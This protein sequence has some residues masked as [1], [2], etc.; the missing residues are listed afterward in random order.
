MTEPAELQ[1]DQG[2]G[3]DLL[4][5]LSE[6]QHH[7]RSQR[8]EVSRTDR[9]GRHR[10]RKITNHPHVIGELIRSEYVSAG[11]RVGDVYHFCT[12]R[13]SPQQMPQVSLRVLSSTNHQDITA[14]AEQ[15]GLQDGLGVSISEDELQLLMDI[16]RAI[17][18]E[19][20]EREEMEYLSP[21][22]S[23]SGRISIRELFGN[24]ESMHMPGTSDER[25]RWHQMITE[26]KPQLVSLVA[27]E[28]GENVSQRLMLEPLSWYTAEALVTCVFNS[29]RDTALVERP[30][31]PHYGLA[32]TIVKFICG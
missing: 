22:L 19:V 11:S 20:P 16:A 18:I 4:H 30:G 5:E 29:I 28:L 17:G 13:T 10:I 27:M 21:S 24:V 8:C 23:K 7:A 2:V 26:L 3:Q 32:K 15:L 1:G 14:W 6:R 25:I 9:V 31:R 12:G